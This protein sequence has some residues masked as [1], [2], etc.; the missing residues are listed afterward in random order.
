[1]HLKG[2][3]E[4]E[5]GTGLVAFWAMKEEALSDCC[6]RGQVVERVGKC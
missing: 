6:I 4:M 2:E 1:M 3:K 5:L